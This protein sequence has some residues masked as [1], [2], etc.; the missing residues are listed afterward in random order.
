MAEQGIGSATSRA[1]TSASVRTQEEDEQD[2]GGER[3]DSEDGNSLDEAI[4]AVDVKDRMTIGCCYYVAQEEKLYFM[5]DVKL[6]YLEM[7]KTC[8]L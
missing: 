1:V 7:V 8:M 3:Q 2:D 5:E 4:M 6:G